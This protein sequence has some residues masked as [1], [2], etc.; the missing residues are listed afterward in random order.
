MT[1]EVSINL[2]REDK[3][4]YI[5][6]IINNTVSFQLIN[7]IFIV[8]LF[9]VF[10]GFEYFGYF[11]IEIF[12]TKYLFY[13][14]ILGVIYQ[15][16]SFIFSYLRLYERINEI[17]KIE[18]FIPVCFWN[19]LFCRRFWTRGDFL[20]SIIGNFIVLIPYIKKK[21]LVLSSF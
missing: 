15:A 3:Y 8:I 2:D 11:Q 18:F 21:Y 7:S 13:I 12:N 20:I 5:K 19:L 9:I 10:F 6:K 1:K 16:K 14:L 17:I 4:E